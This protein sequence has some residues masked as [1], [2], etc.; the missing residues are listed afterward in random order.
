MLRVRVGRGFGF[1]YEKKVE[2][3]VSGGIRMGRIVMS[4]MRMLKVGGDVCLKG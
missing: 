4:L 3:S 1:L 2:G